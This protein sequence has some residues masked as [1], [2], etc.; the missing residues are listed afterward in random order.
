MVEKTA[1]VLS[2]GGMFGA[3]QAGAWKIL[4]QKFQ[5]GMVIGTSVGALNGWAIAGRCEPD[6]LVRHW[7]DPTA[8]G[9]LKPRKRWY[10][11]QSFF[12][13]AEFTA[14]VQ[15]LGSLFTPKIPFAVVI[16]DVLR[17]RSRLF[18]SP[19]VGWQHLAAACAMPAGL[20][21]MRIQGRW[22]AD[23]GLLNVLPLWAAAEMGASHIVA[24]HALP[25]VPSRII[26]S[27]AKLLR[28]FSRER[29]VPPNLSLTLISPTRPLGTLRESVLWNRD[30][31]ERII[32]K[33]A[34]DARNVV[35]AGAVTAARSVTVA[36]KLA[37][38]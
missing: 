19:D 21:S 25:Q 24:I 7:L 36:P 32:R 28:C 30:A 11:W 15:K 4:A 9:F 6:E 17:L 26:R 13:P 5:P 38:F 23:G 10:P 16:T 31:V 14:S 35:L 27:L 3:Y 2:A 8:A 12:D 34:E 20:P 1:L 33:G 37:A 18:Q 29:N 22:Y